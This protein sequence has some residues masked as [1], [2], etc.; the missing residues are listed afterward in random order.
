MGCQNY[1]PV[2]VPRSR[3]SPHWI[4]L[5]IQGSGLNRRLQELLLEHSSNFSVLAWTLSLSSGVAERGP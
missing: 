1:A 5:S 2:S 3:L 4:H